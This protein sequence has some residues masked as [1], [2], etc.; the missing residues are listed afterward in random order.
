V[1]KVLATGVTTMYVYDALGRLAAEFGGTPPPAGCRAHRGGMVKSTWQSVLSPDCHRIVTGLPDFPDGVSGQTQIWN[2]FH[3]KAAQTSGGAA[4]SFAYTYNADGS[5]RTEQYPSGRVVANGY[6]RAAR[7][8]A[9]GLNTVGAT[10]Y[11]SAA[12]TPH[13]AISTL[14]LGNGLAE[15]WTYD[16]SRL[17]PLSMA[18]GSLLSLGFSYGASA[19]NNGNLLG[20]TISVAGAS[21]ASQSFSYDAV[22]R[23]SGAAEGSAWS[24]TFGYDAYGNMWVSAASGVPAASFTPQSSAWFNSN[25]RLVNAGLGIQHESSG[26]LKRNVQAAAGA[27]W[28]NPMHTDI[29]IAT[30]NDRQNR[31]M[32]YLRCAD[33]VIGAEARRRMPAVRVRAKTR[34]RVPGPA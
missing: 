13:G 24:R 5:L 1:K 8:S 26:E 34:R 33:A 31:R 18:T 29:P 14:N 11:A 21:P 19:S 25:N 4:Y 22:N 10:N 7:P 23:L 3:G 17:Q 2:C 16:P 12:Y 6:D 30:A 9:V 20:Q 28:A 15:N 27:C 32:H